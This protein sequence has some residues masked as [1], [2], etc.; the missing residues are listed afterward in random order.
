[1]KKSLFLLIAL[2]FALGICLVACDIN[3]GDTHTHS[4]GEWVTIKKVTCSDEGEMAR[5]CDCGEKQIETFPPNGEHTEVVDDAVAPTCTESGL[6]EG[7]HCSDCGTVFVK[8]NEILSLPHT[9]GD[10]I[11]TKTAN[12]GQDGELARYCS[13]GEKQTETLPPNGEH[14][15]V[16]DQAVA[17]TCTES[18]LTEGKHCSVCNTTLVQQDIIPA[19]EHTYNTYYSFDNSFHWYA[20]QGCGAAKDKA[21][22]QLS[23]DGMC[24]LCDNLIGTSKGIVF[25]KSDDGTYAIVVEYNGSAAKVIIPD[26]YEGLPVTTI[27]SDVFK[28]NG[29]IISV[30]FPDSLT[31]IGD[32]AFYD[33]ESLNSIV[34]PDSLTSIGSYAFRDCINLSSIDFP[35]SLTSIGSYA[36]YNCKSLS[37]VV[38]GDSLTSI[39]YYAFYN[40]TSLSSVVL[41]DSL[42]SFGYWTFAYCSS[43]SSVVLPDSLTS[44]GYAAFYGCTSL[45]SVVLP[46]SLTSIGSAAFASCDNLSSVVFGDSLTSIGDRAF[47]YC[48]SLSSVVLPDSLTSISSQTFESCNSLQFNEYENGKYLGSEGNPYFALI[49]VTTKNLSSYTIHEDTV[50]IAGGVFYGFGGL[51]SI[52]IPDNVTS[53]GSYAFHNCTSLSSVVLPD[54]LTSIGDHAFR[55]CISLTN[56]YYTGS[57]EEWQSIEI[58]DNNYY[59]KNAEIHYNYVPEN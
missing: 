44:I 38:F 56:V 46:D 26:T 13:C 58:G 55:D 59:L 48:T 9:Y 16:V 39:G 49:E 30:I 40:C 3:G 2:V 27:Y 14:T 31:S 57:K 10:W 18:G 54:S 5:Y 51:T 22:H 12:C 36:F 43:L 6:T 32:Y 20:C 8:Q 7:K 23:D 53:I 41:P 19:L 52:I 24:T 1:M 35:D 45:S 34:F 4:F 21:E 29:S 33:C 42:T 11:V 15:E 47:E 17:P 37:S 50:I 25:K 28:N